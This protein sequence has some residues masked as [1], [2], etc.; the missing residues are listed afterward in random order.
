MTKPFD[1][2]ISFYFH[3][4][5]FSL[6][7]RRKLK[8]F[9]AEIF[10]AKKK[11]LGG[12]TYVFSTDRDVLKINRQYLNHDFYTDVITFNLSNGRHIQGEVYLSVDRIKENAKKFNVS[13]TEELHRVIFHAVLHLC[14]YSDKSNSEKASMRKQE[15]E[16]L[17]QYF[18]LFH[19]K[20]SA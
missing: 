5:A 13:F 17:A 12:L 16:F 8:H 9:I 14:G 4:T 7:N 3:K 10:R 19:V 6:R 18:K 15:N 11:S 2:Q 1:P 20:H